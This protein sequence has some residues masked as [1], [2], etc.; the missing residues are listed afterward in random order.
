[1]NRLNFIVAALTRPFVC[2]GLS[3]SSK[4]DGSGHLQL[5]FRQAEK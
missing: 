2:I 3:P 4:K 1:L 5:R